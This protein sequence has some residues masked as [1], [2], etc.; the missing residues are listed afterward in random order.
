M[1]SHFFIMRS[2]FLF[3]IKINK[4]L[5]VWAML[6]KTN[7]LIMKPSQILCGRWIFHLAEIISDTKNKRSAI[8]L[9]FN[10][11]MYHD[12]YFMRKSKY[13]KFFLKGIEF[14]LCSPLN[15]VHPIDA[16]S[17]IVFRF[18]LSLLN[19]FGSILIF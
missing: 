11:L 3:I 18:H 15:H 7:Y 19:C 5:N 9:K 6:F 12:T 2:S 10:F 8:L 13:H 1:D 4:R 17:C 14:F 16:V